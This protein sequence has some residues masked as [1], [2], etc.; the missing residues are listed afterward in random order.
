MI[1]FNVHFFHLLEICLP[2]CHTSLQMLIILLFLTLNIGKMNS[3]TIKQ[4]VC[5]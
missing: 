1:A 5:F 2:C 4:N 3:W